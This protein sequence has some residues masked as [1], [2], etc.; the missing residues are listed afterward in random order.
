MPEANAAAFNLEGMEG[1][2]LEQRRRNIIAKYPP[3]SEVD[4][5]ALDDLRE[6]SAITAALRRKTAHAPVR[7]KKAGAKRKKAATTVDD[8]H[9]MF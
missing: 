3:T 8:V 5:M 2:E 4:D 7:A 9:N 6:L 1:P